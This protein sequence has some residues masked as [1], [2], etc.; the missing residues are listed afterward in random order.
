MPR[1]VRNV[2]DR[3]RDERVNAARAAELHKWGVPC[4]WIVVSPTEC[5]ALLD[6][7]I[8]SPILTQAAALLREGP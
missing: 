2:N 3:E 4:G 7:V 1:L 5:E 8:S 6:G